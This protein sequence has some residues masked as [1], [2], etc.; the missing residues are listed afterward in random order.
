M[1]EAAEDIA[2]LFNVFHDG[3]FT[4]VRMDGIDLECE[5][6]I[7]Y[8]ASRIDPG[9]EVFHLRLHGFQGPS[10]AVWPKDPAREPWSLSDPVSIFGPEPEILGSEVEGEGIKVY[11]NQSGPSAPYSGGELRFRCEGATVA[12]PGGRVWSLGD[13]IDLSAGYWEDWSSGKHA[14]PRQ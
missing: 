2:A 14:A 3:D 8:L 9:Y 13:L 11:C 10:L 7:P 5:I 1:I 4:G 12:D 6:A